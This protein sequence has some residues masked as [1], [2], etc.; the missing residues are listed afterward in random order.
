MRK[1]VLGCVIGLAML[2]GGL[3]GPAVAGVQIAYRLPPAPAPQVYRVTL[4]M[5]PADNPEWIVRTLLSGAVREVTAQNRGKF[6]ETWDGLDEDGFPVKPG[7]YAWKGVYM[8][9]GKWAIDGKY[10]TFTTKLAVAAGS[11]IHPQPDE[12]A[13]P[14]IFQGVSTS[15]VNDVATMPD[16]R[17]L[18]ASEYIE[19]GTNPLLI[20]PEPAG[21]KQLVWGA[22][23]GG[24]GGAKAVAG[25]ED[26][27]Y[28][29]QYSREW[30]FV[31]EGAFAAARSGQGDSDLVTR[32]DAKTGGRLP[33]VGEKGTDPSNV[34]LLPKTAE[35]ERD[36]A[37][38]LA[39]Q[40][41]RGGRHYLYVPLLRAGKIRVIDGETGRFRGEAD[42]L[43]S[44]RGTRLDPADPE[45]GLFVLCRGIEGQAGGFVVAHLPLREG[46]IS[47]PPTVAAVLPGLGPAEVAA[48]GEVTDEVY[49]SERTPWAAF[50]QAVLTWNCKLQPAQGLAVDREGN[51]YVGNQIANQVWKY[52]PSGQL[53]LKIGKEGGQRA[54]KFDPAAMRVPLGLTIYYDAENAGHL[55]V[56][57]RVPWQR[58]SRWSLD[59]RFEKDW[60]VSAYAFPAAPDPENPQ[61]VYVTGDWSGTVRYKVDYQTGAWKLDAVWPTQPGAIGDSLMYGLGTWRLRVYHLNNRTFYVASCAFSSKYIYEVDGYRLIPRAS[62]G[63][64]LLK[65]YTER[66]GI[67]VEN[68]PARKWNLGFGPTDIYLRPWAWRDRN[69]DGKDQLEEI[70]FS[71]PPVV[72]PYKTPEEVARHF[73][74]YSGEY[75]DQDL[76]L[77]L[78]ESYTPNATRCAMVPRKGW[79]DRGNPILSWADLK[80]LFTDPALV[81]E[82][83]GESGFGAVASGPDGSYYR[84]EFYGPPCPAVVLPRGAAAGPDHGTDYSF[85]KVLRLR[86]DGQDGFRLA[87]RVGQHARGLAQPGEMY[88]PSQM[89]EPINGIIGVH[90]VNGTFHLFTTDGLYLD[91]LT[92]DSYA[93]G[94]PCTAYD[95]DGE[96]FGGR[97]FLNQQDGQAYLL[98]GHKAVSIFR[99]ENLTKPGVVRE[100]RAP[101]RAFNLTASEIAPATEW[102]LARRGQRPLLPIATTRGGTPAL[103]GSLDGWSQASEAKFGLDEDHRVEA[104][105]LYDQENLYLRYHVRTA[106]P[107]TPTAPGNLARCFTHEAKSDVVG[108]Y[109]QGD[110]GADPVRTTAALG[111]VRF[112]LALVPGEGG[113]LRPQVVAMYRVYPGGK[114]PV[115]YSSPAG[116]VRFDEVRVLTDARAGYALDEDGNGMVLAAV[117][118]IQ[119]VPRLAPR[120]DLVTGM[121][122]EATFASGARVPGPIRASPW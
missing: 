16:G 89:S 50:G 113:A 110:A 44:P 97:M 32:Y 11:T 48:W 86:P 111:D 52:S 5:V 74:S 8:P 82:G 68:A 81:A 41:T 84:S 95:L 29:A 116:K 60:Y 69:G 78:P 117:I 79:D 15:P 54:G 2:A 119:A 121:D 114:N 26:F 122:F 39:A 71:P 106:G 87:W 33:F 65:S 57:E 13:L 28:L 35:G 75:Y 67:D 80:V 70:D 66:M 91:T 72:P 25:D 100:L 7:R 6:T 37:V 34:L 105:I 120:G 101:A 103:D 88:A 3:V 94:F 24:Y 23:S 46:L 14:M 77:L 59:G 64:Y 10:H 4:A 31:Q 63:V 115:T 73:A 18:F 90:D 22:P 1:C 21:A 99:I 104:R 85:A 9:A 17:L 51:F 27:V 56:A 61:D 83:Q 20:D 55:V 108:L 109:L 58:V 30:A 92:N 47:G 102:A 76:N 112:L 43:V 98:Q 107:P 118:P 19:N 42:G 49:S 62:M 40:K 38:S 93:H 53:L 96:M 36:M 12:D 45:G